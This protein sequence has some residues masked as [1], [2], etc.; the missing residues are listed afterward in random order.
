[1]SKL[2][3]IKIEYGIPI[4][5]AAKRKRKSKYDQLL[6]MRIGG[7]FAIPKEHQTR[8]IQGIYQLRKRNNKF[9][10]KIRSISETHIRIW[11]V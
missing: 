1:M 5:P 9:D 8:I 7:S 11:R 4:P 2:L 3:R 10:V 6:T